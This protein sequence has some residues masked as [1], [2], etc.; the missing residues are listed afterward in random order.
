V[1]DWYFAKLGPVIGI[2]VAGAV[3]VGVL[4]GA[5]SILV[6]V[7]DRDETKRRGF[8]V[9]RARERP[10]DADATFDAHDAPRADRV[11]EP[12]RRELPADP[13]RR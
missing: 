1:I 7:L 11:N 8:R 10:S 5:I 12:T 3:A 13:P 6:G 9:H 2:A 4:G